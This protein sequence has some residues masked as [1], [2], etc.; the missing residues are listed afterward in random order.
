MCDRV[1]SEDLPNVISSPESV[2]GLTPCAEQDGQTTN[3]SGQDLAHANLS[4]RQAKEKGLLTSGICGQQCSISSHGAGLSD[5]L[6]N[7]LRV[8]MDSLGSTLYKLIWKERVTPAGRLIFA[9]RASVRRTSDN[10]STLLLKGWVTPSTRDWKDTPGMATERPD[11]RSRLDQ[12]PRLANLAGWLTPRSCE[13]VEDPRQSPA[14]LKDR[15]EMTC[16]T[17]SAQAVYLAGWPTQS[18]RD[19]GGPIDHKA[20]GYGMQ[21]SDTKI[22]I[23]NDSPARLTDSGDLLTGSSAGMESG[24]QL[25]PAHS[26][27][28][29]GLPP[30]WDDFAPTETLSTLKRQRNLSEPMGE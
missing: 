13:I 3:R 28:L 8:R 29:M 25:D 15:G 24:G 21:L 6:A 14:R 16:T 20:R 23:Q 30:E 18:T 5:F 27:W 26:R 2:S 22:I 7:R 4:A 10:G 19:T 17:V 12:L 9:R 1:I 11:G